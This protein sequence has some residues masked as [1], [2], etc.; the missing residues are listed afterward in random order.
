M[1]SD[2]PDIQNMQVNLVLSSLI[3]WLHQSTHHAKRRD[4]GVQDDNYML[5][6]IHFLLLWE[7]TSLTNNLRLFSPGLIKFENWHHTNRC[8]KSRE[9]WV[10][11]FEDMMSYIYDGF[12]CQCHYAVIKNYIYI[13]PPENVDFTRFFESLF[14]HVET[15]ISLQ[16]S[17]FCDV[18]H[19]R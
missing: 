8:T 12:H 10:T 14:R 6:I 4:T 2:L 1:G 5:N 18:C 11:E 19:L 17:N 7:V 9:I 13:Y 3:T 15:Q 16:K